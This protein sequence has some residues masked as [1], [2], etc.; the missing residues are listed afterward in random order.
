MLTCPTKTFAPSA[1]TAATKRAAHRTRH[2][3]A[4]SL[5]GLITVALFAQLVPTS[6]AASASNRSATKPSHH[7]QRYWAG[8]A[9]WLGSRHHEVVHFICLGGSPYTISLDSTSMR[10]ARIPEAEHPRF[11]EALRAAV[12][13]WSVLMGCNR[14]RVDLDIADPNT[15][16]HFAPI[17]A[18]NTLATANR[19][20]DMTLNVW[21]EWFPGS[22]RRGNYGPNRRQVS[23]YWVVAHELGHVWGLAHSNRRDALMYPTQC[24]TCRWSSYEQAAANV[25]RAASEVPAFSRPHDA[26]RF[27]AKTPQAVV[28]RLLKGDLPNE[29]D[30]MD[31]TGHCGPQICTPNA[32]ATTAPEPEACGVQEVT[33]VAAIVGW[34]RFRL[35]AT[36]R[37]LRAPRLE[38]ASAQAKHR[39]THRRNDNP[40]RSPLSGLAAVFTPVGQRRTF[41]AIQSHTWPKSCT[42]SSK[43][44][45]QCAL[46]T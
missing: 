10:Q 43:R 19:A 21:R 9:R 15:R 33:G 18:A 7:A 29:T 34:Q 8:G 4:Q 16:V 22:E 6:V 38:R 3:F 11:L 17:E 2:Q 36:L 41:W 26:S 31:E 13:D 37:D 25:I 24:R 28:G 42:V 35:P 45:S 12:T 39:R 30:S 14:F 5:K 46:P 32:S 23:F 1:D 27:F 44:R 40:L 20:G